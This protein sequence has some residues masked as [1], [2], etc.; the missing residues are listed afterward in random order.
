ILAALLASAL[1]LAVARRV[2][3]R[4]VVGVTRAMEALAAGNTDIVVPKVRSADEIAEMVRT[5]EVF[6]ANTIEKHRLEEETRQAAAIEH[7]RDE[8]ERHRAEATSREVADLI[9]AAARGD[10]TR[11]I[12]LDGKKGQ[13]LGL[14]SGINSLLETLQATIDEIA[15]TLSAVAEGDLTRRITGGYGGAFLRLKEDTNRLAEQLGE[16][17]G[18]IVNTSI[19]VRAA[20]NHIADGSD[21]LAKR[22]ESSAANLEEAAAAMEELT[23][24]ARLNA[25]NAQQAEKLAFGARKAAESGGGVVDATRSA[26]T[27]V[28]RSSHKISEIIA[29]IDEI[30]FQTNLLALNAAVEAAR[31]GEAGTGFAVVAVQVRALAGRSAEASREIKKLIQSSNR[32]VEE[33][34]RLVGET[35]SALDRIVGAVKEASDLIAAIAAASR[36]Q[37]N[38]LDAMNVS[39]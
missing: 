4:P 10:L 13:A 31:A 24:T 23:V 1:A 30:A 34:V 19:A 20:A 15:S 12:V 9:E 29:L 39:I 5:L 8:E 35:G 16:T 14:C 28:E 17:V 22:S 38:S 32:H 27:S 6:R 7:L 37:A 11:R 2:I 3:I 18:H 36:E 21:D 33:G 26:M 25:D